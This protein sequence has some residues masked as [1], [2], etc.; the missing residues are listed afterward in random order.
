[1]VA[2]HVVGTVAAWHR[3]YGRPRPRSVADHV[4][5]LQ[6][7]TLRQ[8]NEASKRIFTAPFDT[9]VRAG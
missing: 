6:A 1:M 7:V 2:W 3:T 5:A 9:R 8:I 4:Q